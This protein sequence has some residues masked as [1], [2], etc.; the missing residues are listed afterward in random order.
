MAWMLTTFH[1]KLLDWPNLMDKMAERTT[2]LDEILF[3]EPNNLGF[4]NASIFCMDSVQLDPDNSSTSIVWRQNRLSK[5]TNSLVLD[6]NP[7]GAIT[8]SY[9]EFTSLV[10]HNTTLMV[11]V[12]K[13]SM[14]EPC[15][16]S[17]NTTTIS[18]IT[19]EATTT[20]LVVVDIILIYALQYS[21]FYLNPSI[22]YH[23]GQENI[24]ADDK[25]CI[26]ALNE[27][28]FLSH[29]LSNY[30]QKKTLWQL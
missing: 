8:N 11:E 20:N 23:P 30:P 28:S 7:G 26:F 18:W 14:A 9:L 27:T 24:M 3:Q 21:Q 2:H 19:R 25:S 16:G 5:T 6:T 13:A 1:H 15:S 4:W 12:P 22:F 29:I 10:L 17:D